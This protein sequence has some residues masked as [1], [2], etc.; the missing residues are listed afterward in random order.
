MG[1]GQRTAKVQ[2]AGTRQDAGHDLGAAGPAAC[3]VPAVLAGLAPVV[4][5]Q[6][7]RDAALADTAPATRP[8]QQVPLVQADEPDRD[9]P[10]GRSRF[11]GRELVQ[12]VESSADVRI[13]DEP[14]LSLGRRGVFVLPGADRAGRFAGQS[15]EPFHGRG[16]C[17]RE[18]LVKNLLHFRPWPQAGFLVPGGDRAH[19][20]SQLLSER[21][22]A[23]PQR[24]LQRARGAAGPAGHQVH[25]PP[26]GPEM[27]A[28]GPCPAQAPG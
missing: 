17:P 28:T 19:A 4:L 1:G 9:L 6:G 15:G 24:V 21:L 23:Q 11:P 10:A 14:V 16:R 12:P 18:R 20:D 3:G 25:D 27:S 8:V 13:G 5:A 7:F 22:V 26:P 2:P